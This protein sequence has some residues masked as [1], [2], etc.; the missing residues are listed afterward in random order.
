M[1]ASTGSILMIHVIDELKIG[2]AQT[3]LATV[4]AQA[5]KSY[6][7]IDHQ[8]I[9]LFGDGPIGDKLRAMGIP[10]EALDLRSLLMRRRFGSAA[11]VLREIFRRR[12][13]DVVEAHLTWSRLLGLYAAWRARTPLRI[14]FEQGDIYLNTWKFRVANRLAQYF[15]DRIV[16]CS[17]ALADWNQ[18]VHGIA[19][20]K[21]RV[22]YNCIDLERFQSQRNQSDQY[23]YWI[24]NTRL[25]GGARFAVVGTLGRGVDKRT[26]VCIRALSSARNQGFDITMVICGDGDRRGELEKFAADLGVSSQVRFLG[27][28]SDVPS[29]LASCDAFCHAAPFEPFGIACVEA[30]AL[31]LPVVIPDSGGIREAV[32]DD[33]TG[34]LYPPLD[35]EALAAAMIRL[36]KNP[37]LRRSMGR[38]AR[39]AVEKRFSACDY[40]ETLYQMY[41]IA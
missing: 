40:V 8:V 33:V 39:R 26:D 35:H 14:G 36:D 38:A 25:T 4:L 13:P 5:L 15:A 30:M 31:G 1:P 29:V 32:D 6:P 34:L 12:R 23:M 27:T 7:A 41:N 18:Q 24:K 19:P 21:L 37:D 11:R 17:Q 3:H 2:G 20:E 9:S 22:L 10:V 28:C 16:V